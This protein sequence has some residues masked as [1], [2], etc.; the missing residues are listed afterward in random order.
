MNQYEKP[1][2]EIVT[3]GGDEDVIVASFGAEV[4]PEV[5]ECDAVEIEM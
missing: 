3:L 4:E 1:E 5:C 2:V